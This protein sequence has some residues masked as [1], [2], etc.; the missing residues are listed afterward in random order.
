MACRRPSFIKHFAPAAGSVEDVVNYAIGD[1]AHA[2]AYQARQ[3]TAMPCAISSLRHASA[4]RVATAIDE[5]IGD[6]FRKW[7][8]AP[9]LAALRGR[10]LGRYRLSRCR[11]RRHDAQ[12]IS[13]EPCCS[14]PGRAKGG[15]FQSLA[16]CLR[17]GFRV[18][19]S[20][21]AVS[22]IYKKL[23]S[24]ADAAADF[25]FALLEHRHL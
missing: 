7:L 19:S 18:A 24:S 12:M 4:T 16:F 21:L 20:A 1:D 15:H 11:F 14:R 23:R 8:A 2:W 9:M 10:L 13:A 25:L 6:E 3:F 5:A 17:R 22:H